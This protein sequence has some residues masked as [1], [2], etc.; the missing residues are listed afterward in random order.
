MTDTV[1]GEAQ[2]F[3][4]SVVRIVPDPIKDEAINVGV[5]VTPVEGEG[6]RM[7]THLGGPVRSRIRAVQPGYNFEALCWSLQDLESALGIDRRIR[8]GE[9][10][11]PFAGPALLEA[12]AQRLGNQLQL[13]EPRRFL[14]PT[15][16][17]AVDRLFSRYV[18]WRLPRRRRGA[19]LTHAALRDQ[20][21]QVVVAWESPGVHVEPGG[22]L[23]GRKATHPVDIVISNG[24]PRAA[25]FAVPTYRGDDEL[26]YLYRDRIP[27]IVH[28]A[29]EDVHVYAVLPDLSEPVEAH[30]RQFAEE[31]RRLLSELPRT[32]TLEVSQLDRVRPQVERLLA[33]A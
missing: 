27:T 20:I 2:R 11:G 14:A 24:H 16:E 23:A 13:T 32:H 28:D 22:V 3:F 12:V 21:L 4:Y 1:T 5:V 31:T 19:R 18:T 10:P 26:P 6:G 33:E 25:L 15:I 7:R 29:P 17:Q 9:A 30:E 8:L